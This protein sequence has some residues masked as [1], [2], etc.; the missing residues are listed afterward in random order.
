MYDYAYFKGEDILKIGEKIQG[1]IVDIT[2]QGDGV[3]REGAVVFVPDTLPGDIVEV[4]ITEDRKNFYKG[5]VLEFLEP[6]EDR[7]EGLCPHRDACSGCSLQD[8]DY[9]AQLAYKK[10]SL[11]NTL[12][13]IAGVEVEVSVHPSKEEYGYRNRI[14]LQISRDGKIGYHR[15]G[16]NRH[17]PIKTCSIALPVI[18]RSLGKLQKALDSLVGQSRRFPLSQVEIKASASGQLHYIFT[19]GNPSFKGSQAFYSQIAGNERVGITFYDEKRKRY[20]HIGGPRHFDY[21]LGNLSFRVSPQS[22]TQVNVYAT[23]KLY[24]LAKSYTMRKPS[25]KLLDLFSGIG[26]TTCYLSE[27][28]RNL[29]GVEIVPEAVKDADYNAQLNGIENVIFKRMD[30]NRDSLD[31]F[32]DE[33]P[34][35]LVVDPPRA[36]LDEILIEN[37]LASS[38]QHMIYIS[39]NPATLARDIKRLSPGFKVVEVEGVDM[40]PQTL[41]VE[42]IALLQREIS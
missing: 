36:G 13:R 6:S 37:I 32:S 14:K 35:T 38:V 41:H 9:Q 20:S 5:R 21:K 4:E 19:G 40:F 11:G 28:P 12:Q 29:V 15:R 17:L 25:N 26:T 24:E 30:A 23:R 27:A 1:K 33:K 10:N 16:T 39:C 3:L 18:D 34:D 31:I 7:R 42:C 2:S 22:F 8:L